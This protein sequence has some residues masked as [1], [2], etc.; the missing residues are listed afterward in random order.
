M[1]RLVP[2]HCQE[3][4]SLLVVLVAWF[5]ISKK[6]TRVDQDALGESSGYQLAGP[7]RP[8]GPR[9]YRHIPSMGSITAVT[10]VRGRPTHENIIPSRTFEDLPSTHQPSHSEKICQR[11]SKQIRRA[12]DPL[13]LALV[14]QCNVW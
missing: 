8:I 5:V 7:H 11:K 1:A 14:F 13:L 3:L 12:G 10:V 4:G 2:P 9:R 6:D